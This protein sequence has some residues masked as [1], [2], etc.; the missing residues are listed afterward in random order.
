MRRIG[1]RHDHIS[2]D[3][4]AVS[5]SHARCRA[6]IDMYLTHGRV[7]LHVNPLPGHQCAERGRDGR[8]TTHREVHTVGAFE[9]VNQAVDAGGVEWVATYQQWLNRKRLPQFGVLQMP[10]DELPDGA[11]AAQPKQRRNLLEHHAEAMERH[12]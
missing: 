10:A 4:R 3:R 2:C 12:G 9:V 5:K 8:G 6:I 11:V 1:V 7:E